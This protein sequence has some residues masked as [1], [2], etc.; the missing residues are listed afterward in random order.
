MDSVSGANVSS[1]L[2]DTSL[3]ITAR[4]Q[5]RDA[6]FCRLVLVSNETQM[7]LQM[8]LASAAGWLVILHSSRLADYSHGHHAGRPAGL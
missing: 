7:L 6:D 4:T 3:G 2:A 8:L 1:E 5:L